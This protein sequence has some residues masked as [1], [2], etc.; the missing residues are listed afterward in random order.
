MKIT[1]IVVKIE[2]QELDVTEPCSESIRENENGGLELDVR[3]DG[4]INI[5]KL[6]QSVLR[7]NYAAMRTALSD[8]LEAAVKKK[9]KKQE[10]PTE[11]RQY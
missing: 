6:E 11:P 9:P 5:D 1:R 10:K 2:M 7:V 3:T 4:I 8:V